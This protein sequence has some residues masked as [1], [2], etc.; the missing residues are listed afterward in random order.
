MRPESTKVTPD[1]NIATLSINV[2]D[3]SDERRLFG[4]LNEMMDGSLPDD[5]PLINIIQK[6]GELS[7]EELAAISKTNP[8]MSHLVGQLNEFIVIT[9]EV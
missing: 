4:I 5:A 3:D 1:T 9:A 7:L 2:G 8:D 6:H